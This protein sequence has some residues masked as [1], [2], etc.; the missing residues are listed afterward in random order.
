MPAESIDTDVRD[1]GVDEEKGAEFAFQ[2]CHRAPDNVIPTTSEAEYV[3]EIKVTPSSVDNSKSD[4]KS[5]EPRKVVT[6]GRKQREEDGGHVIRMS[7]HG[8]LMDCS[9]AAVSSPV[10]SPSQALSL[11]PQSIA[12]ER[13][14]VPS[15]VAPR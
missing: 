15:R 2:I 7:A 9:L 3:E 8:L 11:I 4:E 6:M 5:V 12:R 13:I 10:H 1:S 14:K